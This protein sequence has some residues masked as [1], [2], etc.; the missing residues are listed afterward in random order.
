MKLPD[1]D[2]PFW[3]DT[4]SAPVRDETPTP[5]AADVAIVGAGYTGL[6]AAR[7]LARRGARVVVLEREHAGWG[8]SSRNGGQVLTGMK[9]EP[10]HLISKFGESRARELFRAS[11]EAIAFLEQLIRDEQIDCGFERVGHLQA[12]A[13]PA[14]FSAFERERD[15]LGARFN[16]RVRLVCKRDQHTEL[17]SD[18]YFGVLVD[19]ESAAVN[20]A[21]LA[22][23]LAAAAARAGVTIVGGA[24]VEAFRRV[25]AS[26][27]LTTTRGELAAHDL[28]LATDAYTGRARSPLR[29][30]LIPIG[31]YVIATEPLQLAIMS[32]L[33]PRRRMAFDSRYF[34]HYWRGTADNRLLFGGRASFSRPTAATTRRCAA[35]LRRDMIRVFPD[36]AA[37]RIDYAWSGNVAFT[38]DEMPRAGRLDEAYYAGGYC[39]HGVAMAVWLGSAIARRMAGDLAD[40]ILFD[41]RFKPVPMYNGTP[42]FLPLAGAYYRLRDLVG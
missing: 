14:H 7:E 12:A 24:A 22:N 36:L 41:D 37:T 19:E 29:R 26:W 17:G 31:S 21:R 20:P 23:G 1:S 25:G 13:K 39:G 40:H 35:I 8:A 9:V 10:A 42:W 32:R 18:A 5:S 15:L 3:W 33:M 38:L 16:H 6:S 2:R 30:R 28:L 27:I 4:V 11:L 34:L